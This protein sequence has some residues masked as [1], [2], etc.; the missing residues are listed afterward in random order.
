[1]P[2][3][4]WERVRTRV[5]GPWL[6]SRKVRRG[7]VFPSWHII[8][9]S[10]LSTEERGDL[11][12]MIKPR[13]HIKLRGGGG[14]DYCTVHNDS[15]DTIQAVPL[16]RLNQSAAE[17]VGTREH[18]ITDT[19]T[20]TSRAWQCSIRQCGSLLGLVIHDLLCRTDWLRSPG[21]PCRSLTYSLEPYVCP[22][23]RGARLPM[24]CSCRQQS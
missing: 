11:N 6:T 24:S 9:S 20:C 10:S 3:G 18:T 13:T 19:W 4:G 17:R 16:A 21:C 22:H 8:K 23:A 12:L 15:C 5:H 14:T 1:M 2:L 7:G